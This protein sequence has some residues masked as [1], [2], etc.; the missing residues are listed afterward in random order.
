MGEGRA[1][2]DLVDCPGEDGDDGDDADRRQSAAKRHKRG[3]QEMVPFNV[4]QMI[5]KLYDEIMHRTGAQAVVDLTAVDKV[6][7]MSCLAA[8]TPYVG[9]CHNAKH[10]AALLRRV[11]SQ[12]FAHWSDES[13]PY[14]N[15][16]LAALL[17]GDLEQAAP[18]TAV[19]KAKSRGKSGKS[20]ASKGK[21]AKAI[22]AASMRTSK[23]KRGANAKVE[24]DGE[25]GGSVESEEEE[26]SSSDSPEK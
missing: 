9:M 11:Q 14:Y 13:K 12:V 3:D 5:P 2:L 1:A 17:A 6:L 16:S 23:A 21:S 19:A 25:D 26:E 22:K 4:N 18:G 8:G 15:A 7:S 20:T 10:A 24:K